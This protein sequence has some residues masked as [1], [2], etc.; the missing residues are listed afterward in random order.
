MVGIRRDPSTVFNSRLM[1]RWSLTAGDRESDLYEEW[2]IVP[3]QHNHVL[4][5]VLGVGL[6]IVL[7]HL[8][9]CLPLF[10]GSDSLNPYFW[11]GN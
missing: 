2:A 10:M 5:R 7:T 8:R 3:D 1:P 9:E 11:D 4:V 6:V